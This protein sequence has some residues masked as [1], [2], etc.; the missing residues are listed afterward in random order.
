L[1]NGTR[2]ISPTINPQA[3]D[4]NGKYGWD[5]IKGCWYVVVQAEGYETRLSPVVGVPPKVTDLDLALTP[6]LVTRVY[7]P[8]VTK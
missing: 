2:E 5:V 1:I 6:T 8:L 4:A 3:T 7:L